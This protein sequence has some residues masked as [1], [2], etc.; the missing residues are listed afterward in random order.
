MLPPDEA[1][2]GRDMCKRA[3]PTSSESITIGPHLPSPGTGPQHSLHWNL[4]L[5]WAHTG[6]TMW[7]SP[8]AGWS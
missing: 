2:L 4:S 6:T 5:L 1:A 8:F 3:C 7:R